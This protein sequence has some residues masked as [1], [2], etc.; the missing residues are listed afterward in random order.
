MSSSAEPVV[1]VHNLTKRFGEFEAVKGISFSIP[2]GKIVGFLGPNGAGKTSTIHMLLGLIEP[3]AGDI[4]YFGKSFTTHR[5]KSLQ[6]INYT[7]AYNSLL[8]R[9][10]VEQNLS[11]FS[12]IYRIHNPKK[13]IAQLA[14]SFEITDLLNQQF[15]T[16]SAG[17]KTRVNLVKALL[18]DPEV[19][20]M[21]EPTASLDPDIADKTL[22]YIESLRDEK[23]LSILF[24]S[25]KMEEVTRICDVVIFLD[26]GKIVAEDTPR[27]LTKNVK[28]SILIISFE[29]NKE[30]LKKYLITKELKHTFTSKDSVRI[31]T[32]EENLPKVLF[33]IKE[34]G[35][36]L[37]NIDIE[38]PDLE[39]VFLDI[40]RS[41]TK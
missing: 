35:I 36:W 38:K 15:W 8:G 11:V 33:G 39:D 7:S 4:S 17:Q 13:I 18:N 24:T 16:L 25:H 3:T 41:K 9:I 14:E 32:L 6:K 1:E 10:T 22:S 34:E 5:E 19:L 29:G 20:L 12:M 21:D 2:K 40:A 37:K 30:E 27:N 31:K 23:G 28:D 26:H